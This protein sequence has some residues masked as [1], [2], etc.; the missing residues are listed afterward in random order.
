[1]EINT[2]FNEHLINKEHPRK[3]ISEPEKKETKPL[4]SVVQYN[5]W[6]RII[7]LYS[8]IVIVV[9]IVRWN[10]VHRADQVRNE[11]GR[12]DDSGILLLGVNIAGEPQLLTCEARV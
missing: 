7:F 11:H 2:F 5:S 3:S 9:S 6:S 1:M 4:F 10:N 12:G 8:I